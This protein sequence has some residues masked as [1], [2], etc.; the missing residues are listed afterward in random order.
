MK[1]EVKGI[2]LKQRGIQSLTDALFRKKLT[3]KPDGAIRAAGAIYFSARPGETDADTLLSREDAISLAEKNVERSG[4]LTDDEKVLRAM[5]ADLEGKY[6]PYRSKNKRYNADYSDGEMDALEQSMLNAIARVGS[7]M[8]GGA[9]GAV[10]Q[11]LHSEDPCTYCK[12]KE[13]CRATGGEDDE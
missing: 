9:A 10:P 3:G 1:P 12:M 11:K 2:L 7:E 6:I 13:V 5:E 8:C 4:I